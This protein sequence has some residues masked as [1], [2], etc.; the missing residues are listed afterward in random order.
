[1]SLILE[2]LRKSEADRRRAQAPD[3]FAGP[4][5]AAR[6]A[7]G[8]APRWLWPTLGV[9]ALVATAWMAR[10]WWTPVT[11]IDE[12]APLH[13]P[14]EL[15]ADAP[16]GH[17]SLDAPVAPRTEH[18]ADAPAA[19]S[20]SAPRAAAPM[21]PPVAMA[22]PTT[23]AT[24]P[25]AAPP[26]AARQAQPEPVAMPVPPAHTASV[27]TVAALGT[28]GTGAGA[29]APLLLSDLGHAE[30][31]ALPPLKLSMHM[32]HD[33]PSQRFAIVDGQRVGEGD[34]VGDAVVARITE[35]GVVLA[36]RGREVKLPLP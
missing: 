35:D 24:V 14:A 11:A 17:A 19:P 20:P 5:L 36:W 12:V 29:A 25:R 7:P 18:V 30:R 28:G 21:P 4:Q 15:V 22:E 34:R 23:V 32:W 1:M 16:A 31:Q 3:L 33:A 13:G 27:T 2:A 9:F 6:V 26:P 10:A 8:A